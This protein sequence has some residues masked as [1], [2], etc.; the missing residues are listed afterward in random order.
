MAGSCDSTS[1]LRAVSPALAADTLAAASTAALGAFRGAPS[2][3]SEEPTGGGPAPLRQEISA[4]ALGRRVLCMLCSL[5]DSS[6]T[7]APTQRRELSLVRSVSGTGAT[8]SSG[9]A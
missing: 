2:S 7:R 8:V 1:L 6:C 9:I 4:S 5:G 3:V